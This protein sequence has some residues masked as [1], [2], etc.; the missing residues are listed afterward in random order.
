MGWWWFVVLCAVC[1]G[2]LWWFRRGTVHTFRMRDLSQVHGT[3][4]V[5]VIIDSLNELNRRQNQE[6]LWQFWQDAEVALEQVLDDNTPVTR[7]QLVELL[8]QAHAYASRRDLAR[9]IMQMRNRLLEQANEK[10][11]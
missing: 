3:A 1:A 2:L 6:L 11:V 5:L 10:H 7:Q 8:H 9:S 4:R